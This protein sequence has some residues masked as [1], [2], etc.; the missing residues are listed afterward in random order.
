MSTTAKFYFGGAAVLL[1]AIAPVSFLTLSAGASTTACGSACTSP[2]PLDS[3]DALTVSGSTV[4]L[5]AA[6]TTN[7]GQDWT[8]QDE[9]TVGSATS[10]GLISSKFAWQ[11]SGDQVY[12]FQYAPGG[13]ASGK[14]L[15][16]NDQEYANE[17][18]TDAGYTS[19]AIPV[20]LEQCGVD[21]STLWIEDTPSAAP[22]GYLNLISADQVGW[23][24]IPEG[25]DNCAL[26]SPFAEPGVLTVSGSTLEV[27]PLS[28]IGGAVPASQLWGN[29][30]SAAEEALRAKADLRH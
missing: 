5:A 28:E 16:A 3:S 4:E 15:A 26:A 7:T 29:T 11:Y 17:S 13:V 1:L 18:S 30:A 25:S 22:S 14:C 27:S 2:E 6:S 21:S 12:E 24:G 23:C 8:P 19:T 10:L 9:G 20:I